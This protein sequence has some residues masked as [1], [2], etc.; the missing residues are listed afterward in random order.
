MSWNITDC[1]HFAFSWAFFTFL[2]VHYA[3][4]KTPALNREIASY[5]TERNLTVVPWYDSSFKF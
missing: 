1:F 2:A 5:T 4:M 3:H